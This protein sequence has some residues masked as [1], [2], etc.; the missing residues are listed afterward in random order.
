M[1]G[2]EAEQ[3]SETQD[4]PAGFKQV[5]QATSLFERTKLSDSEPYKSPITAIKRTFVTDQELAVNGISLREKRELTFLYNEGNNLLVHTRW[6]GS[7]THQVTKIVRNGQEV[8]MQVNSQ[9]TDEEKAK[10]DLE[11]NEKWNPELSTAT[12]TKS[13]PIAI[14]LVSA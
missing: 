12:A 5:F 1:Q 14:D 8:T 10:F 11:W 6:I 4:D 13:Y 3:T 7:K 9:M 2:Q